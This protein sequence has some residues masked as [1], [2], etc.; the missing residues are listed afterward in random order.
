MSEKRKLEDDSL[1]TRDELREMG[2]KYSSTQYQRW[3]RR[4][5]S[6]RSNQEAPAHPAS[7]TATERL[8]PFSALDSSNY[9]HVTPSLTGSPCRLNRQGF[10]FYLLTG[11]LG[12][13]VSGT[14]GATGC[15]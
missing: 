10:Y 9:R 7:I 15:G 13:I 8:F 14:V 3:K 5:S 2:L 12:S 4:R 1:V 6:H 11:I